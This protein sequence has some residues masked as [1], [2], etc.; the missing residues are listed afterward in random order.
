MM[1]GDRLATAL[2]ARW[3]AYCERGLEKRERQWLAK[4]ETQV[5]ASFGRLGA[6][7]FLGDETVGALLFG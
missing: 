4:A 3:L 5:A 6:Q 2:G 7:L 1:K